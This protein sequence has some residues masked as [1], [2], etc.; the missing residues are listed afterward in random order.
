MLSKKTT[1][2]S[3]LGTQHS[4]LR[5]NETSPL[6]FH[7]TSCRR[8]GD[9]HEDAL[10][11]AVAGC[12]GRPVWG[13]PVCGG[14]TLRLFQLRLLFAAVLRRPIVFP[15]LSA[16]V[17]DVL[18]VSVRHRPGKALADLL[19]DGPRNRDE[20]GMQDLL[21]SRMQDLLSALLSNVLQTSALHH[22]QAVL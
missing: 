16:T 6:G 1:Q 19:S 8:G 11:S 12:D 18:Q 13:R 21:P 15:R 4:E 14:S 22:L 5:S 10:G 9:C 7:T 20:T 17:Q 2:H 3:A